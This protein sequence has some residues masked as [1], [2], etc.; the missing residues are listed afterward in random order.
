MKQLNLKGTGVA[1]ITPFKNGEINYPALETII[2]FIIDGGVEFIVSLGTTG[3]AV[4][5]SAT[6]CRAVLDFTIKKTA[7][8]IPIVAGLFGSN[9]TPKLVK[10]VQNYDFDGIDCIM[11]SSPSYIKPSQ[12]GI[13]QHYMRLAEVTP[14]PVIIYNVPGRTS[15][16]VHPETVLRL[17]EEAP[18]VFIAVKEAAGDIVQAMQLIK[19]KPEGFLVLSGDDPI[20]FPMV[21]AGADGTISVIANAYPAAFSDMVRAALEGDLATARMLNNALLDVHPWLYIEGNPSGIKSAMQLKGLCSNELRIPL[22]ALTKPN[23]E[24]LKQAMAQADQLLASSK[25]IQH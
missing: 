15:S 23:Y 5:L 11:S 9:Y 2:N 7:G 22:T 24:S 20:T 12:E 6:E 4:N 19:H 14:R 21:A 1:I 16:N 18:E 13:F 10:G 17:A 3:E 25:K 8:R